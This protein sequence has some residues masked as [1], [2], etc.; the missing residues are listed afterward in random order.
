MLYLIHYKIKYIGC[1]KMLGVCMALID[2]EEDISAFEILYKE[3]KSKI[4][5][6]A[7]KILKKRKSCGRMCFGGLLFRCEEFQKS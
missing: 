2:D 6:I 3:C 7:Y 5:I 1:D 4:Y